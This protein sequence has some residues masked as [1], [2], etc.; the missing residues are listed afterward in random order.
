M[1]EELDQ[2]EKNDT[3]ELVQRPKDKNVT[4]TK[5]VFKNKMNKQGEVMRNKGRLV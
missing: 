2:I 3:R 1:K 4:R 5:W